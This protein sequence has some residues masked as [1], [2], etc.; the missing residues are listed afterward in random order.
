MNPKIIPILEAEKNEEPTREDID[1]ILPLFRL[2]LQSPRA[3]HECKTCPICRK[4]GITELLTGGDRASFECRLPPVAWF[5]Q[6]GN[7]DFWIVTEE[8]SNVIDDG[9]QVNR[10]VMHKRA[11][12]NTENIGVFVFPKWRFEQ[13]QV[14]FNVESNLRQC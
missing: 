2:L 6:F 10:Q 8:S 1:D 3:E 12:K 9:A 7:R 4:Y 13:K 11:F 5:G 14:E